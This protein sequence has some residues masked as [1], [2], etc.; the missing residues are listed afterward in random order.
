MENVSTAPINTV[1]L[2]DTFDEVLISLNLS[3]E[4]ISVVSELANHLNTTILNTLSLADLNT[5][6]QSSL[7][8]AINSLRDELLQVYREEL[9]NVYLTQVFKGPYAS[10]AAAA[11]DGILLGQAYRA[12]GGT[13]LW[14]QV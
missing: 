4:R 5:Q 7:L 12:T 11:A 8:A 13:I 6:D 1:S 14:R 9:S 2:S 3:V 10:D